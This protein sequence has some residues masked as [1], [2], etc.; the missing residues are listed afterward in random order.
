MWN[1][2]SYK[3]IHKNWH[4]LAT[5]IS[6]F[7]MPLFQKSNSVKTLKSVNRLPDWKWSRKEGRTTSEQWSTL[8]RTFKIFFN[9]GSTERVSRNTITPLR[10]EMIVEFKFVSNDYVANIKWRLNS[11]L[12][13]FKTCIFIQ[14]W[15][16]W[17]ERGS[18]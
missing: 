11:S 2:L 10:D 1:T 7:K 9:S 12:S 4:I 15:F 17:M 16:S 13:G 6:W 5:K 14:Q 8:S 3:C 18:K